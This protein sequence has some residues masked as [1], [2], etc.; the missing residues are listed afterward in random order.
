MKRVVV[1]PRDSILEF[2]DQRIRGDGD[3][4][5][6]RQA[7]GVVDEAGNL[8]G[9]VAYFNRRGTAS[10][11]AGIAGIGK[12]WL[13]RRLLWAMFHYPFVQCGVNRVTVEVEA[14][15]LPS[16]AL[17]MDLGFELEARKEGAGETGDILVFRMF[18]KDCRWL[19]LEA[20]YA[21]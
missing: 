15:N 12:R 1:E 6:T 7:I 4:R 17:A 9:G 21:Q 8:V 11:E 18:K 20:R 5:P 14:G 10:I 13:T 19:R 16:I 3:G 2:I